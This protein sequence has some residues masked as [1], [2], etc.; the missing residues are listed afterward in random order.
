MAVRAPGSL[1]NTPLRQLLLFFRHALRHDEIVHDKPAADIR[2]HGFSDG[3]SISSVGGDGLGVALVHGENQATR[4][5]L[6][7]FALAMLQ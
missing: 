7:G 6:A 1:D 5:E 2:D 4:A 3:K